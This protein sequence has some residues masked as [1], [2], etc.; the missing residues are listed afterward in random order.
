MDKTVSIVIPTYNGINKLK[1]ILDSLKNQTYP[2]FEIIVSI[3][4]STDDSYLYLLTRQSELTNLVILNNENGGRAVCR[5]RGANAAKGD[6]LIFLDDDMRAS[7]NLVRQHLDFH[8]QYNDSIIVGATFEDI[9]LSKTDIQKY[10]AYLSRKWS[11]V[12]SHKLKEPYISAANF[13]INKKLFLKLGGFDSKLNDAE[14]YDLAITAFENDIDIFFYPE[15]IGYHDDY[16]SCKS[17]VNRLREYTNAQERL[18]K[19]KPER[20][21]LKFPFRSAPRLSIFS[22]FIYG[23]FAHKFWL[24]IVDM[25]LLRVAPKFIKY[26]IYDFVITGLGVY[27]TNREINK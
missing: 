23:C 9:E 25:N 16:I 14:D 11:Q 24:M 5:N 7:E 12:K 2:H 20:Y 22:A 26:K 1:N 8:S 27:Y 15:I 10:R 3:D 19:I 6:L 18:K 21:L 4:G 13:S 17:Y